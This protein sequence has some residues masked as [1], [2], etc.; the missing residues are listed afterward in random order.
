MIKL[1]DTHAHLNDDA[2]EAD[3]DAVIKCLAEYGVTRVIDV[4]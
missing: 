1:F 4:A 3:R 2:F